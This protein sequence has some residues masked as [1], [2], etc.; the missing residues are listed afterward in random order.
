LDHLVNPTQCEE[1]WLVRSACRVRAQ[2][3]TVG[4]SVD[5]ASLDASR[6]AGRWR[7]PSIH[8]GIEFAAAASQRTR[9]V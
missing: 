3:I 9:P 2:P 1:N 6:R 7:R 5:S 4:W 8:D